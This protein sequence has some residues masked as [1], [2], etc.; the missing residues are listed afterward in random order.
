MHTTYLGYRHSA[1]VILHRQVQSVSY[2]L[3]FRLTAYMRREVDPASIPCLLDA[4]EVL[5]SLVDLP[6][7]FPLRP[8]LPYHSLTSNLLRTLLHRI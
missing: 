2:A 1:T 4:L 6:P 8:K 3:A 7:R 5:H